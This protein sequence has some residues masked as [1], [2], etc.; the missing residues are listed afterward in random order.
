VLIAFGANPKKQIIDS[1][2]G[3]RL[4]LKFSYAKAAPRPNHRLRHIEI[5]ELKVTVGHVPCREVSHRRY[6]PGYSTGWTDKRAFDL[7]L[8]LGIPRTA[9]VVLLPV[10]S[11]YRRALNPVLYIP[12]R[13]CGVALDISR[14]PLKYC[15]MS[16]ATR[17]CTRGGSW[18]SDSAGRSKYWLQAVPCDEES[19]TVS[20]PFD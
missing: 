8:P 10:P 1:L 6:I 12:F 17:S 16:A 19:P 18:N 7:D 5:V 14:L 3:P 20:P 9:R 15:E 13:A 4:P 11:V 2:P